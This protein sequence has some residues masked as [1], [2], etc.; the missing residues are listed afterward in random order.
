MDKQNSNLRTFAPV[1]PTVTVAQPHTA[2]TGTCPA[3]GGNFEGCIC[4][5]GAVPTRRLI[6]AGVK[7]GTGRLVVQ[8]VAA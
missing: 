6:A 4:K 5:G 7:R 2:A 8:A 1:S 3:C